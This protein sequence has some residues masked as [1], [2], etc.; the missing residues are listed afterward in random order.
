MVN[1]EG[2]LEGVKTQGRGALKPHTP[3]LHHL[4]LFCAFQVRVS[5]PAPF[6][7]SLFCSCLAP[8][9]SPHSL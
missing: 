9:F 3:S 8:S 4:Q 1:G 5:V 6:P 2:E 7:S